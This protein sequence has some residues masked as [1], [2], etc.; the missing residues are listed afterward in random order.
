MQ[1][2]AD[3]YRIELM[4]SVSPAYTSVY[5]RMSDIFH[6]LAYASTIRYSVTGPL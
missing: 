1:N 2:C 4:S 3:T 6:M 5:Q